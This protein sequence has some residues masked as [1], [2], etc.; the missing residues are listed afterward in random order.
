VDLHGKRVDLPRLGAELAAA[1]VAVNGLG[2]TGDELHQYT[3]DGAP[4]D[5]P[6]EGYPIVDAHTPPP[7]TVDYAGT[8]A[9]DTV[10]RT[11][12]DQP[13]EVFRFPTEQ[14]HVYRATFALTAV[15][16]VSGA[17]KDSEARMVFKR[18]ASSVVQVGT[19]VVLSTAQDAAA[20]SWAIVAGVVGTDF[21]ISVRGA[22]G[23]SIDWLLTGSIGAYAPSGAAS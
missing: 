15:D 23:R 13:L 16:A 7:R 3:A 2:Q 9:V 4:I 5:I 22:A 20:S 8:L 21:T 6:P 1:G 12:D 14:R 18:L 17:V 19:T 10:T 11:T